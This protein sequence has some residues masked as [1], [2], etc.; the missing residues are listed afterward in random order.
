[1]HPAL[2]RRYRTSAIVARLPPDEPADDS[3]PLVGSS[4]DA[5]GA[6]S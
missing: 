5:R 3:A 2:E 6:R 4:R 1:M